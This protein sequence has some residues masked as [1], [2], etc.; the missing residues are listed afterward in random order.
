M[1]VL[2]TGGAGFIGSHLSE[3][4]IDLNHEVVVVDNLSTGS[5]DNIAQLEGNSSFRFVQGDAGISNGSQLRII[6]GAHLVQLLG[7]DVEKIV[8]KMNVA[9][10]VGPLVHLRSGREWVK[11]KDREQQ[12]GQYRAKAA[13]DPTQRL[14]WL[15]LVYSLGAPGSHGC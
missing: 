10:L 3:Y 5:L 15:H 4:L 14:G 11:N 7:G 8:G 9:I 12:H 6:V 13:S 2:I 1:K